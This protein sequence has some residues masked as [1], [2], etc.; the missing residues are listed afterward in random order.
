[1]DQRE[2]EISNKTNDAFKWIISGFYYKESSN[3]IVT[4]FD[5]LFSE[6]MS[7]KTVKATLNVQ[8]RLTYRLSVSPSESFIVIRRTKY[9]DS[10][11]MNLSQPLIFEITKISYEDFAVKQVTKE[12]Y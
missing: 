1:M 6:L 7:G 12:T 10:C 5:Q 3:D 8:Q 11:N 9:S 4:N 2:I